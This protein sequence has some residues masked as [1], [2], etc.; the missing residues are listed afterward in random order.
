MNPVW[1]KTI[2]AVTVVVAISGAVAIGGGSPPD[3]TRMAARSSEA[4]ANLE[5][6]NRNIAGAVRDTRALASIVSSVGDQLDASRRL[7]E[8]QLRI[9]RTSR[10]S[11]ERSAKLTASIRSVRDRLE[12]VRADLGTLAR[13]AGRAGTLTR[14]SADAATPLQASLRRLRERFDELIEESRE[15]NRKARGYEEL[16]DGPG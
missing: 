4:A 10:S 6:A 12:E 16:R 7:L 13:L 5:E 14:S 2:S 9:E 11:A 3:L 15:L 8:T 1:L